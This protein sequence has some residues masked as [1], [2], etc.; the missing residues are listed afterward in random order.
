[1]EWIEVDINNL[2]D[3]EVVAGSFDGKNEHISIGVLIRS[4]ELEERVDCEGASD[5]WHGLD[6]VTHYID[7]HKFK[8]KINQ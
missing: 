7:V 6:G 8:P 5:Y 2:P 4:R 3:G 1:M